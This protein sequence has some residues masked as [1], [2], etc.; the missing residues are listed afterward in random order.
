M[1]IVVALKKITH[2]FV[3][4]T[5]A[6]NLAACTKTDNTH[7]VNSK[8]L[9]ERDWLLGVEGEDARMELL[10]RYL[11]GFDQPM[12]E[13]GQRYQAIYDALNVKN[14]ELASYHWRK[15]KTTIENGY[16]KRPAR[17]ENA[18]SFLLNGNWKEV[19]KAFES[20]NAKS[21]WEGFYFSRAI[22]MS[23]HEAENVSFVNNQP[24]F[25]DTK[26]PSK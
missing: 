23:C 17:K 19:N 4:V 21:A 5:M 1:L 15:I 20:K 26:K 18:D 12:L 7:S 14:Y 9:T 10:Q 8:V 16:L 22:C 6:V 2:L 13:V 11:R 24:L 25:N 3:I